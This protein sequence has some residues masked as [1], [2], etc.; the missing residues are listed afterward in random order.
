VKVLFIQNNGIQE[1]IGVANLSGILKANGHQTDLLLVS[2]TPDLIGAIK[3]Y[4]PGLIAF[5]ALTGV[6]HSLEQLA[7]TIKQT[8][9]VPIIVGGPHP[10]YSPDMINSPGIDIICRGEGELAILDLAEAMEHDADVT[11]IKNLHV[12][13]RNGTI[14]KNDIRAAVPLDDLPF[15]DRELYYKYRF[16]RDMPMKRFISSMGC[17][18]PCTFCHEPVIRNLYKTETKSD[19]LR[20]KSVAR[21]VAEIKYI[22]DRYPLN[23]V[24]FSDDLFFI[25]NSYKWLEEFAEVYAREVGIPFNCNI[26]YDSITQHAADLLE[27]ARCYGAAVGLESG[28]EEIR[29]VVIRKRSKNEHIVEGARLL[30]EKRIKVLTT[31][32]I[33]LP[34]ETLDNALET[35]QLN[36]V[37]KSNYVRAN[38]FLLFPGLPLVEYA[39]ANGFVDKD[40]DIDKQIAESQE[41]TL[42]TPYAKEFR[43]IASLFWLMVKFSPRWLPFFKKLVTLPDNILFR[44]IGSFNMMQELLFYRVKPIP[45]LRYFKNTVLMT[46]KS[47]LNMSLRTIPSLFRKK[48]QPALAQ[49]EIYEASRGYF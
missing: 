20:R 39:R 15:P 8:M 44:I 16:L 12:K 45:A 29:E 31:N 38:T 3:A 27:Q 40:F 9:N 1:S 5:S 33:G 43:N 2:H 35:V 11:G 10:T 32:M 48:A 47:Q 22:A 13:T 7:V 28:N 18:Y 17:P 14:Y 34:G 21:A 26:R 4:D 42:K 23:H 6:H 49:K 30:R 19:Y 25:R 36:M 37:L 46:G 24:H 41:I